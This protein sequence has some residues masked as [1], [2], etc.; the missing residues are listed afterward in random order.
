MLEVVSLRCNC[1]IV[2]KLIGEKINR[3]IRRKWKVH[4]LSFVS[5]IFFF[6]FSFVR[7]INLKNER[8]IC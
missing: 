5:A 8:W 1:E 6:L 4:L 2:V 3:L 7:L